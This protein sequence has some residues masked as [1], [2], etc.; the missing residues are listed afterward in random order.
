MRTSNSAYTSLPRGECGMQKLIASGSGGS[1]RAS[2]AD[3][4]SGSR[5]PDTFPAR[6]EVSSPTR[7]ALAQHLGEPS[8]VPRFHRDWSVQVSVDCR[9]EQLLGKA[10]ATELLGQTTF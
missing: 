9:G 3:R 4:F 5:H 2:G 7:R 8:W 1:H 10:E 6:G